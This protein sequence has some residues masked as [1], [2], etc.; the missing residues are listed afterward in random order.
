MLRPLAPLCL[1][2]CC[3]APALGP[4]SQA[5]AAK[6]AGA[7][8][9][10]G[11]PAFR[12]IYK[13]LVETN[14]ALSSGSCTLAADRMAARLKAA[15]FPDS[16]LRPF[17][18]ADH[19]KEGGLVAIYP[20]R[21]P[22]AK[23]ILLLAHIDVV[24]AKREDWTRDP[25]KLIEEN[26]N[27][28]ARGAI[29][30][31]AEAAIWV[32]TLI[33]YKQ[34]NFHPRRTLKMALTCGEET[35]GAFN[36]AQWLS[37]NWRDVIDAEFAVNEGALGEL[38]ASGKQVALEVQDGEKASQNYRLEVTNPGGHSSRPVK[39]NA[40]YRL[41]AG[42]LKIQA[43]TFPAQF[44]DASRAFFTG[45]ATIQAAKGNAE[46]ADAMRALVKDPGDAAA[47]ALVSAKDPLWNATLRT[48]CVATMLDAGHA[49]NAL[50]QRARANVNCRIFP[51][52]ENE[53]I[54]LKLEELVADPEV[55]VTTLEIRGPAVQ[56]PALTAAI[57][58]PVEKLAEEYF[59]GVPVLPVLQPGG[60]DGLFMIAAGI[61]TYGIEPLFT[62]A[63][64]GHIHG[65]NEFVSVKS[66]MDC[67]AFL[68]RLIKVYAE[69]K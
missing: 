10:A 62:G 65:L 31:K 34:E 52:V 54:R 67:R 20:G 48:T 68:Y 12:D 1:A 44:T 28:Y 14:T 60:T 45:L 50:P 7:Q 21:D 56:P 40:I 23:A 38:D 42:L 11:E 18:A 63:D 16:D 46:V 37:K 66:L 30:D 5:A 39:D 9:S 41:S 2:F 57:M 55:K 33:R 26:G 47:I 36:G 6:P 29:D 59:P 3:L 51:G 61:P 22:K 19:P 58:G 49:T 25:F 4:S 17:A 43:Y 32:D 15:G 8:A 69:Q 35:G 53:T 24:E 64:L 27:F 13:E